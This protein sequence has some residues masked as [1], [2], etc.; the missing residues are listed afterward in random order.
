[1]RLE[2]GATHAG[3][4]KKEEENKCSWTKELCPYDDALIKILLPNKVLHDVANVS[5]NVCLFSNK[6]GNTQ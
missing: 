4:K 2:K 6:V 1:M 3:K 5:A